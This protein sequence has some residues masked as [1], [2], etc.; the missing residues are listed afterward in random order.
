ME[1]LM[2]SSLSKNHFLV[3]LSFSEGS[4]WD[5]RPV[6]NRESSNMK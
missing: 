1:A 3:T 5:D 6:C 4:D 2:G